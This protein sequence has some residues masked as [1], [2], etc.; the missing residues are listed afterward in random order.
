MSN[1]SEIFAFWFTKKLVEY[2]SSQHLMKT[3]I[4]DGHYI[5][6]CLDY[7]SA[8][9]SELATQEDLKVKYFKNLFRI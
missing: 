9:I 4:R 5:H 8:K 6:S 3:I 7:E 2:D 1:L